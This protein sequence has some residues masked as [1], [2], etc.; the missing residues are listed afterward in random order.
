MKKQP[1]KQDDVTKIR[2]LQDEIY[3]IVKKNNNRKNAE[4]TVMFSVIC[5]DK[6]EKFRVINETAVGNTRD[7]IDILTQEASKIIHDSIIR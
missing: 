2:E 1:V 7:I 4:R 3:G 6:G 5:I